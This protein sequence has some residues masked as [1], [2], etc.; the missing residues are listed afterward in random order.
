MIEKWANDDVRQV[1]E[2]YAANNGLTRI[3]LPGKCGMGILI[4]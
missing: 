4:A 3:D 1:Y 2:E